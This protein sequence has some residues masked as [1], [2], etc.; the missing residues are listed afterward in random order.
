MVHFLSNLAGLSWKSNR[1]S[2]KILILLKC[3]FKKWVATLILMCGWIGK[4]MKIYGSLFL[5]KL[6]QLVRL[7]GK[8]R[9]QVFAFFYVIFGCPT[10]NSGPVSRG[11]SYSLDFNHCSFKFQPEG[12]QNS[13]NL[14]PPS[15]LS[16][17]FQ[18]SRCWISIE[19]KV[20]FQCEDSGQAL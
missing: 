9:K 12:H 16:P 13:C 17:I 5:R 6:K 19:E 18:P 14:K 20:M 15:P 7:V 11:Q 10:A 1:K 4:F 3:G 8:T 2:P